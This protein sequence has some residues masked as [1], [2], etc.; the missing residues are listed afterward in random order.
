MK[1]YKVGD[2]VKFKNVIFIMDAEILEVYDNE[3]YDDYDYYIRYTDYESDKNE[4]L[5]KEKDIVGY[6]E[7]TIEYL[8]DE[9][10][11][12]LKLYTKDEIINNL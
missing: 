12:L 4:V 10:E 9:L 1:K 7:G 3:E 5:V 8:Q 11:K 2:K 6:K